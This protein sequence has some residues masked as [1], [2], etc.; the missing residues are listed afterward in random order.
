[1]IHWDKVEM[2]LWP[3]SSFDKILAVEGYTVSEVKNYSDIVS[4]I[5]W[6]KSRIE[7]LKAI[8]NDLEIIK[9]NMLM[10]TGNA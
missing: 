3:D 1:M 9:N 4:A 10:E 8:Q 7:F 6:T 5:E 2:I